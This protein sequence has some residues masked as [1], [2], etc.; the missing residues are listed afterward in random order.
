MTH[1]L[2][3]LSSHGFGHA[4]QAAA[5]VNA[6]R[7]RQPDLKLTLRTQLPREFLARRFEG[8]FEITPCDSDVGMVMRSALDVDVSATAGAY[9]RFHADWGR[10]VRQEA[11]ALARLAPSLILADVPYLTLAAA[12]EVS[13]PAVAMCSLNWADIYAHYFADNGAE[14]RDIHA[15]ILE[16]YQRATCFLRT[17]PC[18]PM[19]D[20]PN[21]LTVGPVARL[22][23]DRRDQLKKNIGLASS[24]RLVAISLGGIDS[25]LPVERW[26]NLPGVHW[27]VPA[28][29]NIARPDATVMETLE[30]S[31]TDV[32]CSVEALIGK[33]GY[34]LFTEAACNGTPM[35]Y[36]RRPDWPE[37]PYLIEWLCRLG[38][39]LEIERSQLEHGDLA[40]ALNRLWKMPRRSPVEPTGTDQ[41]ADVLMR[42]LR[43][44]SGSI[45]TKRV[46]RPSGRLASPEQSVSGD[47]DPPRG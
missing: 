31:F 6:L 11:R 15:Q 13:I 36:V 14:A 46:F 4:A 38:N 43:N 8:H 42:Y 21:R 18:M 45:G 39:G 35:L 33:P 19:T 29:W 25:R 5:V 16:A 40:E 17:E 3:A 22:G 32:L 24:T 7:C 2:V 9:A 10:R 20:L 30:M 44:D 34:G 41:A 47:I 28:T 27:L 23:V 37:E 12:A 26:P 1:L